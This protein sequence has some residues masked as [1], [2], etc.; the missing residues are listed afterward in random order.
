MP[1]ASSSI[2]KYY[3]QTFFATKGL[4]ATYK[5]KIYASKSYS[6]ERKNGYMILPSSIFDSSEKKEGKSAW[7]KM[8]HP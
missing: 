7:D 1:Q 2:L 5:N 8:I 6:E 4:T 3:Q